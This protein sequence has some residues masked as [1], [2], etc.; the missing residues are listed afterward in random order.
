MSE[1][2]SFVTEYLYCD[3]CYEAAREILS[4]GDKYLHGVPIP[5][6]GA[7]AR[8]ASGF[9]DDKHPRELPIV[10]GKIGGRFGGEEVHTFLFE[11]GPALS[12]AMAQNPGCHD[13][14][15]RIAV[16]PDDRQHAALIEIS[17]GGVRETSFRPFPQLS[18]KK[19]SAILMDLQPLHDRVHVRLA[20]PETVTGGG[21]IIP[22]KAQDKLP[23]RATVLA[24]G[25]GRV[26]RNGAVVPLDVK[27]GDR[28][29]LDRYRGQVINEDLKELVVKE[30]EILAVLEAP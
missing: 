2:G 29:L 18:E 24:V 13:H 10:A 14:L 11:L 21:L 28:V 8:T 1:R 22:E 20:P 3:D 17:P 16:L 5:M 15:I 12:N 7:G 26:L 23:Q 4:G 9:G 6:Y 25:T 30:D 27:V 19:G